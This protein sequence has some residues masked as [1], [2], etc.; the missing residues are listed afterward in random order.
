MVSVPKYVGD[1]ARDVG[2]VDGQAL[3]G[4]SPGPNVAGG[5]GAVV[6]APGGNGYPEL[7]SGP[8]CGET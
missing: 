7:E 3:E 5:F 4:A 6:G 1:K 8:G 2:E